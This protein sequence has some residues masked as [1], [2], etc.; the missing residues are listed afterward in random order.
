MS[1]TNK[2]ARKKQINWLSLIGTLFVLV[3]LGIAG[4]FVWQSYNLDNQQSQLV[5]AIQT[6]KETLVELKDRE[7]IG[8]RMRAAEILN[9]AQN[10]RQSWSK[11]VTDLNTTFT[12][13][14]KIA[15][16]NVTISSEGE[17]TVQAKADSLLT[18][19]GF[20]VMVNRSD[21]FENGFINRVAPENTQ[22]ESSGYLFNA[23]LNYLAN[24]AS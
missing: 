4:F 5:Q 3:S 8:E 24:D 6:Q 13:R 7:K 12:R 10:Y 11:I 18:A 16:N 2:T 20:L 22:E 19:A 21:K 17:I 15:F 1:E 14:G 23:T 9:Q